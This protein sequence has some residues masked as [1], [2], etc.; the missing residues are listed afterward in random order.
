MISQYVSKMIDF[1]ETQG[2]QPSQLTTVG[3]SLGA[4]IAG[5]SAR[6]AKGEVHYVVG[7]WMSSLI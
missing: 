1:L 2:M 3:H 4:H 5:L 6:F 7:K